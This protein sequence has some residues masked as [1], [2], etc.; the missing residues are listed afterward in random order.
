MPTPWLAFDLGAAAALV[1]ARRLRHG[2]AHPGWSWRYETLVQLLR[3]TLRRLATLPA[4]DQRTGWEARVL[5]HPVLRRVASRPV[6]AGGVPARWVTPVA[7]AGAP[8]VLYLHGGSYIYGSARTHGELVARLAIAARA[9][10]LLAEYRLAPEH[11]FPAAVDDAL[12]AYRWLLERGVEPGRVVIAGDSAGGGLAVA[13]LAA[14]RDAGLPM[15]AGAALISP[16]VDLAADAGDMRAAEA[17]DWGET[18]MFDRWSSA[19]LGPRGDARDPLASPAHADL[20][21]LPPLLVQ[22]GGAELLRRQVEAFAARA[23][24]AGVELTLEVWDG[25]VHGWHTLAALH[26]PGRAAIDRVGGFV[27]ARAEPA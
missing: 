10:V 8:V 22:V 15:P 7:G 11:P 21:G 27:R 13:T 18:W 4:R 24:A 5:P 3:G 9:R 17:W 16:W 20:R 1:T 25:E 26:R 6:I 14:A 12:A 19:Y 23:R 2:P